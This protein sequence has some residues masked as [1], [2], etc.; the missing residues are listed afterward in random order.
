[1]L[2]LIVARLAR[3]A[4][5][6][7]LVAGCA[8]GAT[9]TATF[10]VSSAAEPAQPTSSARVEA[11]PA[12]PVAH[13]VVLGD[14]IPHASFCPGCDGFVQQYARELTSSFGGEVTVSNRSRNDSAGIPQLVDQVTVEQ[15]TRDDIARADIVLLSIG[16]N[17]VMPD[18]EVQA[19]LGARYGGDWGCEG[20]IGT[21]D[22][23][24]AAWLLTTEPACRQAQRAAFATLY[25]KLL[26]E[27]AALRGGS[28]TVLVLLNVYD[29]NLQW[30]AEMRERG[31]M[32]ASEAAALSR[33]LVP[34]YDDWNE[35]ECDRAAAH[36]FV[37]L[38]LY[39]A[40]NGSDGNKLPGTLTIDGAHPSQAGNDLIAR[41]LKDV[42]VAALLQGAG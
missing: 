9:P 39:H 12:G 34:L 23:S 11:S 31:D 25:D 35:M 18:P 42:D 33:V 7:L 4:S 13:V 3:G 38:D 6:L 19:R 21:S 17:N 26:S 27:I 36:G 30:V 32:T 29:A 15:A 5:M 24:Y 2:R 14:S 40:F 1:M 28:P 10:P 37:C 8:S 16:F 22:A 20:D 41:L